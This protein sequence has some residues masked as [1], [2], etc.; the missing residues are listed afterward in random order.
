MRTLIRGIIATALLFPVPLY[1]DA[2]FDNWP[3][4]DTVFYT[5]AAPRAPASARWRYPVRAMFVCYWFFS[6][7]Q[8]VAATDRRA[9]GPA[10][11]TD[12]DLMAASAGDKCEQAL[13]ELTGG[14]DG[15]DYDKHNLV[16]MHICAEQDEEGGD[17]S[18]LDG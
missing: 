5:P 9:L 4:Q 12:A 15:R 14:L 17:W 13:H 2:V 11:S 8:R 10:C 18:V 16:R 1:A 7:D 6:V 3:W